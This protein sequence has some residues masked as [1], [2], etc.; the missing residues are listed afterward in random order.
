LTIQQLDHVALVVNDLARS[1]AFYT[2]VLGMV[3][4]ARPS[5]RFPG[6]WFRLGSTQEL[7]LIERAGEKPADDSRGN[8][9]ALQV[10]AHEPYLARLRERGMTFLGPKPRPDGAVQVF[11]QD[12]DG[13]HI[14]LCTV[15]TG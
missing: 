8:H 15:A 6:A 9:F 5:F 12:P 11:L 1:V 14:E 3:P 4:I 10:D 7:H 2:E 13:H